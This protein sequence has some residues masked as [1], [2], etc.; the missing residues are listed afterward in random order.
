MTGQHSFED[1]FIKVLIVTIKVS[2][3]QR[4]EQVVI[5]IP[6]SAHG[7]KADSQSISTKVTEWPVQWTSGELQDASMAGLGSC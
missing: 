6:V 1:G 5:V 3:C 2:L 7:Q 4:V